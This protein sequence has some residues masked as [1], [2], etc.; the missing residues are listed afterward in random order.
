MTKQT[1]TYRRADLY[2]QVWAEPMI[3]V[4]KKYGVTSVALAK[5][6]RRLGVPIPANGHWSRVRAGH[7]IRRRWFQTRVTT[8]QPSPYRAMADFSGDRVVFGIRRCTWTCFA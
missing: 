1:V 3:H 6:C 5:T 4:A 7:K 2:E 8:I